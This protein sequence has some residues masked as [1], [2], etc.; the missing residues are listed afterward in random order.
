M[1]LPQRYY[2]SAPPLRK[3]DYNPIGVKTALFQHREERRED[4]VRYRMQEKDFFSTT[5]WQR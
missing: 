5:H 3:A 1:R 2:Y 4:A